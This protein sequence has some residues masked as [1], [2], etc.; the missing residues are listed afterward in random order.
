[1]TLHSIDF[2]SSYKYHGLFHMWCCES[3]LCA[4]TQNLNRTSLL[5][6]LIKAFFNMF[7]VLIISTLFEK[8]I[9]L[10]E[11][12]SKLINLISDFNVEYSFRYP[13]AREGVFAPGG[14]DC[15]AHTM[16]KVI[17]IVGLT[18]LRLAFFMGYE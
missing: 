8:S 4:G 15:L 10:L 12:Q 17:N 3:V 6:F 1:M 5:I 2:Q 11:S 13:L 14:R 16:Q 18:A 9:K 7:N